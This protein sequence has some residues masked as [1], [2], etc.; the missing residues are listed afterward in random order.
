MKLDMDLFRDILLFL[1]TQNYY[2]ENNSEICAAPVP[3][4]LINENFSQNSKA[5]IYYVLNNL[6][7]A[8][9]I[10]VSKSYADGVP[11]HYFVNFITFSGH[12]FLSSI[13]DNNRWK[14]I[15]KALPLVRN[16][17]IDAISAITKGM[18][19]AAIDAYIRKNF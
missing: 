17:S 4:S 11:Y 13:K 15:K 7:Q 1:E 3:I 12:E 6:E 2:I 16:Y 14:G 8:G 5:E 10:N 18:T 9:F 19:A